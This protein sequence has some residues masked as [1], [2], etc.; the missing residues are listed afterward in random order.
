MILPIKFQ[1]DWALL[2]QRKQD[3]INDSNIQE[4]KKRIPHKYKEG[5]KV[6]LTKPG[7]LRKMST[8]RTGPYLVQQ[9]FTNGTLLIKQGAVLQRV[10]LR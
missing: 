1:A 9:V 7:I 2:A 8:P 5:D 3:S 4:N 6:L 10:N